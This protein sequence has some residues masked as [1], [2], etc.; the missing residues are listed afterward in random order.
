MEDFKS[1]NHRVLYD[2]FR[3]DSFRPTQLEIIESAESGKDTVALLP[4]GGGKSLCFQIP[5]LISDGVCLVVTPLIALMQDQVQNLRRRRILAYSIH[6][7]MTRDAICT[8]FE[9]VIYGECKFLYI[10]PERLQTELFRHYAPRLKVSY[11]VVD[12]AHCISQWGYDFR[13]SYLK[14]KEIKSLICSP[15]TIALTAT[16]TKEVVNDIVEHL[17]LKD[18]NIISG[19]FERENLA[20]LVKETD[21]KFGYILRTCT[22]QKGKS[23]IVYCRERKRCEDIVNM[24]QGS[25]INALYYHAGLGKKE[26]EE[27]QKM[28]K[29]GKTEVIVATNAF[30]MGIDKPDVRFVV[31]YDIPD[32]VEAYFQEA[33]RAGRDGKKAWALLL[34]NSSDIK[35]LR[36]IHSLNFPS[37]EFLAQVYQ[38]L[39]TY[40]QIAYGEGDGIVKYFNF[41]KFVV[42][43]NFNP[44]RC[45]YALKYLEQEG[46]WEIT[47]EIDN[48]PRLMF[49]G[50]RDDLYSE[51]T[52]PVLENFINSLLRIY[53]GLFTN[54]VAINLEFI[55][56][57]TTDSVENVEAK[58]LALKSLGIANY[59]PQKVTPLIFLKEDR[60]REYEFEISVPRY[61]LRKKQLDRRLEAIIEYAQ[62]RSL[63]RSKYLIDYFS[64]P[65]KD[66]CG[67]CDICLERK[68]NSTSHRDADNEIKEKILELKKS[69]GSVQIKDIQDIAPVAES[70]RYLKIFRDM[71]DEG[72][73]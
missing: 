31:H 47:D 72:E 36:Q 21:D 20:Y 55:A 44:I 26:R 6:S 65:S 19:R 25:G 66:E 32:S 39:L 56:K 1:L 10:S 30:G 8:T 51:K 58:L 73:I 3:Y 24:L 59:L 61:E 33:G 68:N 53:T 11:L 38:T 54:Q 5:T 18:P 29:D 28:W 37:V 9:N 57:T 7:G 41:D 14:I 43:S 52:D 13:P 71:R 50:K 69:R 40:L 12:E 23:G 35:R 17:E 45:Y 67:V 16:A 46:Y 48:P 34:W 4:T 62:Q 60:L 42:A 2:Y 22:K 15:T 64:Q 70:E 63:C 49:Y 27:R